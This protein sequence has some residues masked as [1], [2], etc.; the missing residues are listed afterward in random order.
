MNRHVVAGLLGL[1]LAGCA[2]NRSAIP[3]RGP[4]AGPVGLT[5]FPSIHETIN[6]ENPKFDPRSL[7]ASAATHGP[8]NGMIPGRGSDPRRPDSVAVA[9]AI[10]SPA[11]RLPSTK[12]Q[13]EAVESPNSLSANAASG[14]NP[15]DLDA[16]HRHDLP[17]EPTAAS[18][19][20]PAPEALLPPAVDGGPDLLSTAVPPSGAVPE[21]ASPSAPSELAPPEVAAPSLPA[22]V[23]GT[24]PAEAP[25]PQSPETPAASAPVPENAPPGTPS[26]PSGS[27]LPLDSVPPIA[28]PADPPA[29]AAAPAPAPA[30]PATIPPASEAPSMPPPA[31]EA[32]SEMPPPLELPST[33]PASMSEP[34]PSPAPVGEPGVGAE[35]PQGSPE[36]SAPVAPPIP[37]MLPPSPSA[38]TPGGDVPPKVDSASVEKIDPAVQ[39]VAADSTMIRSEI[40]PRN[41]QSAGKW[42]ARVGDEVITLNE[43]RKGV[44]Q[45]LQG[46]D[47]AQP[48]SE[49]EVEMV[50]VSV[51]Q[52]LI[53]RSIVVQEAKRELKKPEAFKMVMADAEKSWRAEE[54]DPLL[55]KYAATNEYELKQKLKDKGQSLDDMR[56]AYCRYHLSQSF[57]KAKIGPKMTVSLPEMREYYL[58]HLHDFDR[59]AQIVW[60]EIV[61]DFDKCKSRT[62]ARA[63]IDALLGRLRRGE[64]FAKL[65]AAESHGPNKAKGGIWETSPG[66]Y[67]VEVVNAAL[68]V[69]P[70]GRISQVIEAPTSYHIVRVEQRRAAGPASFAEVEVQDKIKSTIFNDKIRRETSGFVA[71]LRKQTLISTMFDPPDRDPAT[72]QAGMPR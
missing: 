60:R 11:A 44:A 1:A 6:R 15:P 38:E 2:Q 12:L 14:A 42:A 45:R 16:A 50:A 51:L 8:E 26:E 22:P 37:P 58:E 20:G 43:L 46:V 30:D 41:A 17:A 56:E 70:N 53:E 24:G 71:K 64:D 65:A 13:L 19:P 67:G 29:P 63:K 10:D 31:S 32:P 7:R 25:A 34:A 52:E 36:P 18:P 33:P 40:R 28:V 5:S 54:L 59:P 61:I 48:P 47:P 66:G 35:L 27:P 49:Q 62:E 21:A 3:G 55:R 9:P 23:E 68:E 69:L 72:I 57:M 4:S 39:P